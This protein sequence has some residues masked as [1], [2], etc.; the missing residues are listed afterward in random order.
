[1]WK[2]PV[3]MEDYIAAHGAQPAGIRRWRF[4]CRNANDR[5]S[6][7]RFEM[8]GEFA[9]ILPEAQKVAGERLGDCVL[10]VHAT[11]GP[12]RPSGI[13]LEYKVDEWQPGVPIEGWQLGG[14]N[15]PD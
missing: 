13:P 11:S 10:V 15:D 14:S 2:T 4:L 9:H 1:M 12:P 3:D 8:D 5:A 7:L 6:L